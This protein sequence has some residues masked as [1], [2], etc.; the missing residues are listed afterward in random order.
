MEPYGTGTH[1]KQ[2][3]E[4]FHHLGFNHEDA[5]AKREELK[6]QGLLVNGEAFSEDGQLLLFF[7]DPA[8]FY[9]TRLEY[10]QTDILHPWFD[11]ATG[12]RI[13]E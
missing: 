9:G 11:E 10:N 12:E 6:G 5:V 4:T 7:M 13:V 8:N 2:F 3:T 1:S